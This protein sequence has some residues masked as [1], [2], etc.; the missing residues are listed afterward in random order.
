MTGKSA[1]Y[2]QEPSAVCVVAIWQYDTP[3]FSSAC[4]LSEQVLQHLCCGAPKVL[5]PMPV[6]PLGNADFAP[7]RAGTHTTSSMLWVST[8][9]P[10]KSVD[11]LRACFYQNFLAIRQGPCLLN[12]DHEPLLLVHNIVVN[13]PG[14]SKLVRFCPISV[15]YHL[16]ILQPHAMDLT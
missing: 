16:S 15:K 14:Q 2:V 7:Q 6:R 3:L 12:I 11:D 5:D 8:D 1:T 10:P 9:M 4:S 13:D